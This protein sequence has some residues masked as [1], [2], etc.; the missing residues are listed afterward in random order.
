MKAFSGERGAGVSTA[1]LG[2]A[3]A[4]RSRLAVPGG[5]VPIMRRDQPARRE[6]EKRLAAQRQRSAGHCKVTP[7]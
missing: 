4:I 2:D 3:Q 6:K 7:G 5:H 1:G